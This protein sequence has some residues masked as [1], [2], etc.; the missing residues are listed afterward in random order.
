MTP[1]NEMARDLLEWA[2]N[3]MELHHPQAG[4]FRPQDLRIL[5][6]AM[7]TKLVELEELQEAGDD[8]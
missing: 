8:E 6:W 4:F 2:E 1:P 3:A 7:L 5:L